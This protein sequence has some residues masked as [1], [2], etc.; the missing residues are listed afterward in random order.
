MAISHRI[1][2]MIL[3]TPDEAL[4]K[5]TRDAALKM[6]LDTCGCAYCGRDAPGIP[7]LIGLERELSATGN[8]SVF[9]S[10]DK[11]ALPSAAYCN[12]AM[13]HA[14]DFDNNYSGAD[15]HILSIVV[16]VALACGEETG[17]GGR[18]VLSAMIFGVEAAARIAKPY[19]RASRPHSYFLTT[20]LVG[21]WG[22]V[23]TAARLLGLSQDQTVNAM[24]V[25]Y[26]HACGNRQALLERALT[27]R[28]QPAIATKAA[29]Y[30]ALLAQRGITGPEQTFE[31]KGGFYRCYTQSEPPPEEEFTKPTIHAMEE[32][33][34]KQFPTCGVHHA[35]IV[36]ALHLK[37]EHG[38]R[39]DEIE[40]V[41]FFLN[42]DGGTLVSMPF[43]P[44]RFPQIDA[45]FCAPY[46]IALAL[47][48]G[49]VSV[50]D[51][52]PQ[53]ILEDRETIDLARRTREFDRFADLR[54][55]NVFEPAPDTK[56]TK[57]VLKD[58]RV[59]EH[60]QESRPLN[61]PAAMNLSQVRAKF[62][63]CM[64]MYE[65]VDRDTAERT[66]NA[67]LDIENTN[68]VRDWIGAASQASQVPAA[69]GCGA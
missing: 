26:A 34:V 48:K 32:L 37:R 33:A 16:P 13:I 36:S 14:L 9:F 31:G 7:E 52:H 64:S 10:E 29:L 44:G 65:E 15:I 68:D 1:A 20:S 49:D 17:A 30:S 5:P 12:A 51:F 67:I 2:E 66:A 38:F 28:I 25:Y 11:L 19:M 22:G 24:G 58:G 60:G 27:K 59:L 57:V 40:R 6:L 47:V 50:R 63:D 23:A 18:E 41:E 8:G 62:R 45:Q 53:R 55:Q 54:L 61:K 39:A 46:A 69:D 56:Y 21:G 43:L 35:N 4:P 42:E 3:H